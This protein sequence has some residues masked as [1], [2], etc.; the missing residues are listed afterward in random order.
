MAAITYFTNRIQTYN[1][2]HVRKLK[3]ISILKQII[4]NNKYDAT[5]LNRINNKKQIHEQDNQKP[6]WAKFTYVG[7]ERGTL[8]NFSMVATSR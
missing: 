8:P 3:E 5:I 2:D 7:E 6:K 4:H 1:L